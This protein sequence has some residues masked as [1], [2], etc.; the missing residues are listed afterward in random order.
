MAKPQPDGSPRV[1]F[2]LKRN[3]GGKEIPPE[4]AERLAEMGRANSLVAA[5]FADERYCREMLGAY[6]RALAA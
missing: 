3:L 5:E 1:I 2:E 4:E 6:S